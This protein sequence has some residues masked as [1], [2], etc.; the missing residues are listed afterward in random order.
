VLIDYDGGARLCYMECHFT[1]EY[2]REFMFVGDR[3]KLTAFFDNEQNFKI[4]VWKR[5][6]AEP[7]YYYPEK[8][9][10]GHGGGDTGIVDAFFRYVAEGRP[11][12]VGI[13][14]ARDAAAIAIAAAKSEETGLPERIPPMTYPESSIR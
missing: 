12:M 4:M 10:G 7:V 9:E 8:N 3:G 13:Q 5:H 6:E 14:G 1:P 2:T 11:R